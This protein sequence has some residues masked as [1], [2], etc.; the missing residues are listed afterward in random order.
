MSTRPITVH[1]LVLAAI[2]TPVIVS[3]QTTDISYF[4]SLFGWLLQI[5]NTAVPLLIALSVFL[6]IWGVIKYF[7][8]GATDESARTAGRVYMLY[9]LIGLVAIVAVWGLVF[10]IIQIFLGPTANTGANA[11]SSSQYFPVIN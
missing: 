5:A 1:V 9:A 3:A 2:L 10:L 7:I 11:P 6:F 8:Y 4:Y